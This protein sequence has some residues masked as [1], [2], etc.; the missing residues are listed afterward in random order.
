M[1]LDKVLVVGCVCKVYLFICLFEGSM[2][3]GRPMRHLK[4]MIKGG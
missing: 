4:I 1:Y 3:A 2:R